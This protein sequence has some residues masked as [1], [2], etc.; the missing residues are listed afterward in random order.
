ML[1]D[2]A[3]AHGVAANGLLIDELDTHDQVAKGSHR[4]WPHSEAIKA[5]ATRHAAGD[6]AALSFAERMANGLMRS[7]LDRPFPGG[8]IDHVSATEQALVDYVPASSLYHL[9]LAASVAAKVFAAAP[10]AAR[11]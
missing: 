1:Y 8:W 10:A 6:I 7:F 2:A 9:V 5:A 3:A 11:A 4:V